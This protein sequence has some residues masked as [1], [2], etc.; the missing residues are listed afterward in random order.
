MKIIKVVLVGLLISFVSCTPN[1]I[2]EPSFV[3][4]SIST[5]DFV[6]TTTDADCGQSNGGIVITASGGEPPYVYAINNPAMLTTSTIDNLVAG[7]YT[8][9]ITDNAK[10]SISKDV[11]IASKGGFQATA[12]L[13]PSGCKTANGTITVQ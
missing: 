9:I 6:T 11:L 13:T 12:S 7:N 8:I 10:C 4:C 3:D 1:K 2:D 5:L